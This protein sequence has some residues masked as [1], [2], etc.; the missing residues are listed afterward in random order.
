MI[1]CSVL[2]GLGPE[3][4]ELQKLPG[5]VLH[6][7]HHLE[8][9]G[10][11]DLTFLEYLVDHFGERSH[12]DADHASLPFHDGFACGVH[13]VV[14]TMSSGSTPAPLPVTVVTVPETVEGLLSP[15]TVPILQP[16]R[17]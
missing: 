8:V 13:S 2:I 17:A 16:P 5:V 4:H 14:T 7:E 11:S 15:P 3:M 9:H 1:F 12:D 6:Y 10:E